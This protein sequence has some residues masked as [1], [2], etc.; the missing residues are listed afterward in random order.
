MNTR[1]AARL[2]LCA[3]VL[4]PCALYAL[5]RHYDLGNAVTEAWMDSNV[6][7]QGPRGVA[8]Y[9]GLVAALTAMGVP[10][11]ILSFLGGAVFGPLHGALW[12][13]VGTALACGMTFTYA[14]TLGRACIQQR[15]SQKIAKFDTFVCR[16]PFLLTTT[17]RIVPLGSNLLTNFLAGVSRI[18][19]LPFLSGSC[20]G[21]FLQNGI[22]A[23]MGS[24]CT[25]AAPWRIGCSVLLYTVSLGMGF[26]L[27]RRYRQEERTH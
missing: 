18:P 8:A 21:F 16:S 15:F 17:V 13:T 11:Q 1:T 7:G 19:A 25:V 14:R 2:K 27:Y 12:A 3:A 22:F 24:G 5:F 20:L 23:L 10:R 4:L 9:V 26:R 6:R